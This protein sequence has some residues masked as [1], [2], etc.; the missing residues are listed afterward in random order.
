MR[1]RYSIIALL[2]LIM[3]LVGCA[4]KIEEKKSQEITEEEVVK[5]TDIT[6][7]ISE[8]DTLEEDLDMSELENLEKDLD[9]V[10][11]E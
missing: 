4:Q 5:E 1:K 9:E 8:V 6:E 3:F 7:D 11:W 10:D 2:V